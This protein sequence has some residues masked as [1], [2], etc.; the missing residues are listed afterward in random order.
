MV[1]REWNLLLREL[2]PIGESV[3]IVCSGSRKLSGYLLLWN[4]LAICIFGNIPGAVM[5][6]TIRVVAFVYHS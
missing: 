5:H 6:A 2:E 3:S 1:L 4:L